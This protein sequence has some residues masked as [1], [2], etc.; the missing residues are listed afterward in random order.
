MMPE[1][2]KFRYN[3]KKILFE[4]FITGIH[5]QKQK[6]I[7]MDAIIDPENNY[8]KSE[9]NE[10]G[11]YKLNTATIN[12]MIEEKIK[13]FYSKR[14]NKLYDIINIPECISEQENNIEL[15]MIALFQSPS[16][17]KDRSIAEEALAEM[18][19]IPEFTLQEMYGSISKIEDRY[20]FKSNKGPVFFTPDDNIPFEPN[21]SF[22]HPSLF[23]TDYF[24]YKEDLTEEE[25]KNIMINFVSYIGEKRDKYISTNFIRFLSDI[26]VLER[27]DLFLFKIKCLKKMSLFE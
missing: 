24:L 15:D 27:T 4:R 25:Y 17:E 20:V 5:E 1:E 10:L 8:I 13:V 14:K 12:N 7:L 19:K 9:F 2:I 3:D 16:S 6:G 26:K 23:H 22:T 21:H 18:Q 11:Q